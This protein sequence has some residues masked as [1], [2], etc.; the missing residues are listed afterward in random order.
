MKLLSVASEAYPLVKTGG[1]ADVVGALPAALHLH[2]IAVTTL[3]PGY[4]QVLSSLA[5]ARV[6]HR[7]SDLLG[8]A[9]R[10]LSGSIAGYP[11]LVLEAPE[12]FT[13]EGGLYAGPDGQDWPDNWRRFAAFARAAADLASGV[14]KD[15]AY[16]VL[17]AHDWQAA[18][19]P[20]YLRYASGPGTPARSVVTV[21]NIAFQGTYDAGIFPALGLPDSAFAIDGV[22][23]YG[24]V[25]FL[26]AGLAT[27]D[28]ITTVS[29]TY[30][31]EILTPQF[32]MGLEGLIAARRGVLRGIVNGIDPA[33]WNPEIDLA[34]ASRYSARTLPRRAANKRAVEGAFGL[35]PGTGPIVTVISRL[36]W[37]KGMDVLAGTVDALVAMGG[38]LALL[39]SG[40]QALEEALLA[41]AARHPGRVGI[42][43][44]YD[45]P[46]SH[47]LQGGADM[48]AIP[49]RF[50]PCG[51]TQ[52]Y[53]LAYGCVPIVARTGGLADTIIDANE[54]ALSADVATG[55]QFRD[56]NETALIGAFARALR[57]YAAPQ[58]WTAMQKRG[59]RQD[60]SWATSG[61]RYA[62]LFGGL[63]R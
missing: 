49:S 23:Y 62:R 59:M 15:H 33:V 17:H 44:G 60:Y 56:V 31:E 6:V 4:P 63:I 8:A 47:L 61:E 22:E 45:E 20:A 25:G 48:I 12:L 24:N 18:L 52:L 34:L 9:A 35:E 39:G 42:R 37:Q 5:R 55:F 46:L 53:G 41:A 32:G 16:D 57:L 27:A 58:R 43:I 7:W 38:R 2:G 1:L 50:E 26:K 29:P 3:L 10:L 51:L 14:V 40:D 36:T 30:A 11:L 54:A 13:R 28:A 19:A 21:H